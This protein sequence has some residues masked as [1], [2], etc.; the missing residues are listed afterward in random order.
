MSYDGT[1]IRYYGDGIEMDTEPGK[2]NDRVLTHADRVHVGKGAT[3][4]TYFAGKVDEAR[5]YSVVLSNQEIAYLG[6]NGASTLHIAIASDA[7]LYKGEAP[8]S[9][10]IDFRD[11]GIMTNSWLETILWP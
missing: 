2:S 1:T 5:I 7:D 11:Y 6:T 10:C 4:D 9:Q 8:G 3:Q